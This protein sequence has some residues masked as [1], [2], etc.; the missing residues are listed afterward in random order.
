MFKKQ[1]T[2][3]EFLSCVSVTSAGSLKKRNAVG[4]QTDR[5]VVANLF[6][7]LPNFNFTND[8]CNNSL[9]TRTKCFLSGLEKRLGNERD[10]DNYSVFLSHCIETLFLPNLPA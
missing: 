10:H 6:R 9:E 3:F 7:V 2:I 8:N 4:T 5:G 1:K